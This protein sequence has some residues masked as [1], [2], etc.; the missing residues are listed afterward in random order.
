MDDD[1]RTGPTLPPVLYW[2]PSLA[3]ASNLDEPDAV[4]GLIDATDANTLMATSGAEWRFIDGLPADAVAVLTRNGKYWCSAG[5]SHL[6][7]GGAVE[8]CPSCRPVWFGSTEDHHPHHL[9]ERLVVV[10]E[11]SNLQP[12]VVS[13]TPVLVDSEGG[14]WTPAGRS[15]LYRPPGWQGP[16]EPA[17]AWTRERIVRH[18]GGVDERELHAPIR[19]ASSDPDFGLGIPGFAIRF[20]DTS[21]VHRG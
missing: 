2:S 9:A 5:T 13:S 10:E 6:G 21:E 18:Y 8:A 7:H 3:E 1:A 14:E 17:K 20:Y 11:L 4:H 19:P 12:P 15:E 16:H